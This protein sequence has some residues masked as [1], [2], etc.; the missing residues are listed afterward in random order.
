MTKYAMPLLL[1]S[2]GAIV[3]IGSVAGVVG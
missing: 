1:A 2:A 3:N